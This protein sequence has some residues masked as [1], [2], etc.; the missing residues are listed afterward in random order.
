MLTSFSAIITFFKHALNFPQPLWYNVCVY[1]ISRVKN[2]TSILMTNQN[3]DHHFWLSRFPSVQKIL[4]RSNWE[5]FMIGW[6]PTNKI[7]HRRICL[8]IFPA[9]VSNI[10]SRDE[11][12]ALVS[13]FVSWLLAEV[14]VF[15]R[16]LLLVNR[17]L[18]ICCV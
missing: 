18:C 10:T 11:R 1:H 7:I 8:A 2:G 14:F 13:P 16:K 9:G 6:V 5:Y 3:D 12:W 4:S 15:V 17:L